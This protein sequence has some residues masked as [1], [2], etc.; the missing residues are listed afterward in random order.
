ML[1]NNNNGSFAC[2][3]L[4]GYSAKIRGCRLSEKINNLGKY[5]TAAN[6]DG[7]KNVNKVVC[8]FFFSFCKKINAS[9]LSL[10]SWF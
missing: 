1:K 4:L 8:F 2:L 5:H 6:T 7:N 9:L 10:Q 3:N